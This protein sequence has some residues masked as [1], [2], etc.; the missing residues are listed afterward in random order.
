MGKSDFG[1]NVRVSNTD[2]WSVRQFSDIAGCSL[3]NNSEK[4]PGDRLE[5]KG[6]WAYQ[7]IA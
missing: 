5:C 7:C 4:I 3:I 1:E 6:A 2:N